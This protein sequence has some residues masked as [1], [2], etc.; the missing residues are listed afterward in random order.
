MATCPVSLEPWRHPK[1]LPCGHTIDA[2]SLEGLG[3]KLC[4]VC[5]EPF[6]SH[7]TPTNYALVD[8][9]ELEIEPSASK[10]DN[11]QAQLRQI[12]ARIVQR[13]VEPAIEEIVER[14][15]TRAAQ[16]Y[17]VCE[18]YQHELKH[19][20]NPR[21]AVHAIRNAVPQGLRKLGFR[22]QTTSTSRF[23]FWNEYLL[24]IRW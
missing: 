20:S 17:R 4:P 15:R 13:T 21:V 23:C 7:N 14:V 9:L 16:G 3:R 6:L 12:H 18:F 8:L 1:V 2:T 10:D 11:L 24:V 19:C 22:T 5:R